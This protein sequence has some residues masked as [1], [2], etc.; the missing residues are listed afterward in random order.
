[1]NGKRTDD[2]LN[3]CLERLFLGDTIEQCLASYPEMAA[4]LEPL[5]RTAMLSRQAAAISPRPEFRA[6]A[7]AELLRSVSQRPEPRRRW[8]AAWQP[9]WVTSLVAVL[10]LLLAGTGTVAASANSMPDEPL[11]PVKLATE[12]VQVT[13]TRSPLDKAVLFTRLADRRVREIA[14]MA[15][16]GK[17]GEVERAARR[18][19]I[20]LTQVARLA[21]PVGQVVESEGEVTMMAP[22]ESEGEISIMA[23]AP[24]APPDAIPAPVAPPQ[25][26]R[27]PGV[28]P[29]DKEKTRRPEGAPAERPALKESPGRGLKE[30][31]EQKLEKRAELKR[32]L[33]QRAS[34]HPE[35]L[36]KVMDRAPESA[37]PALR[38]A[39]ERSSQGYQKALDSLE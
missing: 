24:E 16:K 30:Q 11:Y 35:V 4:E 23:P 15:E 3:I 14:V 37:K 6:R 18:L 29:D 31:Q 36:L 7:R 32:K 39:I 34:E 5:L 1:M 26:P 27:P 38:R 13:L 10:V 22:A 33:L 9:A 21:A 17:A 25:R 12:T 28:P 2:I 8:F 20:H 19:D